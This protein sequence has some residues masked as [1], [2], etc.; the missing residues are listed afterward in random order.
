MITKQYFI[1][2][3]KTASFS[4][5]HFLAAY[6]MKYWAFLISIK[7]Y[8]EAFRFVCFFCLMAQQEKYLPNSILK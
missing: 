3:D 2:T 7:D 1:A 6:I 4:L 5:S 8:K